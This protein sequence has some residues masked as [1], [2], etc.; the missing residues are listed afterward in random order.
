[1]QLYFS[2]IW[3]TFP[4]LTNRGNAQSQPLRFG[5][6]KELEY[7]FDRLPVASRAGIRHQKTDLAFPISG[8]FDCYQPRLEL[9]MAQR[10]NGVNDQVEDHL[11]KLHRVALH[12]RQIGSEVSVYDRTL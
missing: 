8:G 6:K 10:L 12:R 7:Q 3:G 1:M 5:C 11:L 4:E 2:I 9:A